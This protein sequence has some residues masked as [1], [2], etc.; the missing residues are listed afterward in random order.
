MKDLNAYK[1]KLE[2]EKARLEEELAT[3]GRRNPSNPNDWE[4]VPQETGQEPDETDA[5]DL[6]EG[7]AENAA[8]LADLEPRYNHVLAAL[9]RISDGTYGICAVGKEEIEEARLDADP[10]AATC[11]AHKG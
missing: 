3:I 10:T 8:I 9:T 5:A 1:V 7:F 2:A 4:A 6:Q 11:I